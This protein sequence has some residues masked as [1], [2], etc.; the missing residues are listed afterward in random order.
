VWSAGDV[1]LSQGVKEE[2]VE[3]ERLY[4]IPTLVAVAV[5]IVEVVVVVVVAA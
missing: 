3:K 5:G 2:L 1:L 4:W